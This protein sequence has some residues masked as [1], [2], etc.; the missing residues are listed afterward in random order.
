MQENPQI[1]RP[2]FHPTPQ[3]LPSE[4]G[5]YVLW[6]VLESPLPL[7][8]P[9]KPPLTLAAGQYL[10]C[11]SARGPGGLKARLSRHWRREKSLRWHID[12]LSTEGRVMGAWC[13]PGGDEC[14]LVARLAE[15]AGWRHPLPG[16]GS[17]DCPDC[18]SHLLFQS[19]E[20][21]PDSLPRDWPSPS[22]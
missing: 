4:K 18:P 21:G 10:Y 22:P 12:R 17:S 16:F 13:F 3:T 2:S 9:G 19:G 5:A 6:L 14:A 11:G 1:Q 20:A 15:T 7:A 8:L